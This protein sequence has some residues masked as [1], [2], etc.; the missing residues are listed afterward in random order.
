MTFLEIGQR[1]LL[2]VVM[3]GAIGFDREFKS[4]PAGMRTHILVCVGA[5]I[6]AILQTEIHLNVLEQVANHPELIGVVRS[7]Q[8]RLIAQ[9]ISGIG[10]LGAG[11]IIVTK[12][13]VAGLT[14]AA[15]LWTVACLGLAAGMGYYKVALIGFIVIQSVLSLLKKVIVV[16]SI[17]T[18]EVKYIHRVETKEFITDYFRTHHVV[19]KDINVQVE[20]MNERRMYTNVYTIEMPKNYNVYELIE[21]LSVHENMKKIRLIDL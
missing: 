18:L 2:A 5:T 8:T 7:D 3:S 15:S 12:R 17:K 6:I 10:F 4:R 11:T 1:L 19:V 21:D 20:I 16:P 9:V 14:T 13:A